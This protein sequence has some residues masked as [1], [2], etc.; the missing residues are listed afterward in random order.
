MIRAASPLN[1]ES[2]PILSPLHSS[3]GYPTIEQRVQYSRV[4]AGWH[5]FGQMANVSVNP[6]IVISLKPRDSPRG[7]LPSAKFI[8]DPLNRTKGFIA[9]DG[10]GD[11]TLEGGLHFL[12][13]LII[14]VT[15]GTFH[16]VVDN[17]IGI[18]ALGFEILNVAHKITTYVI[19]IPLVVECHSVNVLRLS[20]GTFEQKCSFKNVVLTKSPQ[21]IGANTFG[22]EMTSKSGN[23]QFG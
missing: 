10:F 9:F 1:I 18:N 2:S 4:D 19:L 11:L 3:V 8:P 20:N 13:A 14:N 22:V 15:D 5:K 7:S 12:H 23:P 17:V 6:N 21:L 16:N